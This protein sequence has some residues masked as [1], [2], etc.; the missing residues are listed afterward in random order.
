[1]SRV[2]SSTEA[3]GG[4]AGDAGRGQLQVERSM[5]HDSL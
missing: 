3:L 1:M 4:M 5:A 2:A